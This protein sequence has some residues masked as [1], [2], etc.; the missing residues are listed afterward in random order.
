MHFFDNVN[1]ELFRPLTGTNKRQNMD[2]LNLLWDRCR[3]MPMYAM[4]K[5]TVIDEIEL[6]F[7]GLGENPVDT[8]EDEE[9]ANSGNCRTVAT[10]FIRRLKNTGWLEIKDGDYEEEEKIAINY[11]VVPIIRAFEEVT[12]PRIVTYKGKLFKIYTL[13]NTISQQDSPY[14]T[15][16]K[17]VSEDMDGLNQSLRQ[18]A[19]SIEEHIDELTKGRGPEEIL[20]LFEK[21]EEKIVVG[22][23]HRFKTNDNLFY[24]RT[25]LYEGLDECETE[26][27]DA[28]IRDYMEVE[29]VDEANAKYEIRKLISKI[30]DD[31]MEM[32]NIIREID[33]KHIIYRT[34]AV[35]RAQFQ[36]L[37]DGSVKNKIN[38][39]LQYYATL[40]RERD[41]VNELDDSLA[42]KAFQI[43]GQNYFAHDSLA[44]P[45][46]N[47]KPT[48]IQLMDQIEEL[49][50]ELLEV[51]K[52]KLLEYAK[53]ALTSENINT[54]AKDILGGNEAISAGTIFVRDRAM[55]VKIIGLYTFS[56]AR[57][58]VFDI[59]LKDTYV[60]HAG[61][62]FKDF[63]VEKRMG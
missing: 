34:R 39:M 10:V 5:G 9:L 4:E 1:E 47:R 37:S 7:L 2:I 12:N 30:R 44:T 36:L 21:Y 49:D 48:P 46:Q 14:E 54:F 62:R 24:Y 61:I 22:A 32:E 56:K 18:L 23:Y 33:D 19:A 29:Q 31:V 58:R 42:N 43:Y 41:D 53:N 55:I 57:D 8:S 15:V 51:E 20:S 35:Q 17:E 45:S 27:L 60:E 6:Y 26:T 11:K 16:L 13:L 50:L 59:V 63:T 52:Q 38:G 25:S 28:L 40:I 3:R